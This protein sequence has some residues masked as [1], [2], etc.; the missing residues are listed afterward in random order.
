[1]S[2]EPTA[3]EVVGLDDS[4]PGRIFI[5]YRRQETAWPARQLHDVLVEYFPAE[6]VFKDVDSIEP[7]DDFVE[8]ITA[9]VGSCDVLLALIGPQWV[10][11]ID[12][13]G[14]R[15][16]DDPGDYVRVEIETALKRKIRVIPIL[17]DDAR[18]PRVNEL[19][20][21]LAPLV[22]RNAV[23]INPATFDTK[24]LITA[25]QKTL[26]EEQAQQHAEE[27]VRREV[28]EQARRRT[29]RRPSVLVWSWL[30]VIGFVAAAV[31]GYVLWVSAEEVPNPVVTGMLLAAIVVVPP[32]VVWGWR[33]RHRAA[34]TSTRGQ[35]DAAA[36]RLA[37]QTLE[38]WS[39]QVVERGIQS[40]A[41][42]RVRW[43]WAAT[44]VALPRQELTAAPSLPTDPGPLP[45]SA[46]DPP[47]A[48][49]VLNSGL[50][51]RLHDEVYARL[52]HGRL[53]LI[54]GPGAGKTGA[55]ILLLL[56]ALRYRARIPETARIDVPVPVWLTLGS[57]DPSV[58]GLRDW[59]VAT[60]S[61]DHPYLRATDF[62]PDAMA[63]LFDTGRIALFLDGLDEMPDMQ[64]SKAVERLS[65]E[66]AGR[67]MVITSRPEE[68]RETIDLGRRQLPYTAAIELRQVGP[69]AAAGYLLEGQIGAARQAWQPVANHLLAHPDSVLAKT[70]NT[71]LTLSL[72]RAAYTSD[73][74]RAL[75]TRTP[76]DEHE[77]RVHLLDQILIA[78]Y[79]DPGERGHATHWLGWLAHKMGNQPNGPIRELRW[80]QIPTWIP[81]WQVGLAGALLGGLS[82]GVAVYLAWLSITAAWLIL[83]LLVSEPR[84]FWVLLGGLGF[85]LFGALM[86]GLVSVLGVK[87]I[88]P[89]SMA[90]RWPKLRDIGSVAAMVLRTVPVSVLGF[91]LLSGFGVGLD[92]GLANGL[93]AGVG[94][95]LTFGLIF[96]VVLGVLL[97][98]VD[99]W[100]APLAAMLAVTPRVAYRRDMR[101]HRVSGLMI[102]LTG[103][104]VGGIGGWLAGPWQSTE[105]LEPGWYE[106]LTL[107]LAFGLTLGLLSG[108]VSGFRAG[109]AP[110]LLFTEIALWPRRRRVRFMPLLET[111][112]DRQVLRQAGAVYQFRHADLQD[113]LAARYESGLVRRPTA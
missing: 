27:Q 9:A 90:V 43:R 68:F 32:V 22:R 46:D 78:A 80:W 36:N 102:G 111:A 45:S 28:E 48:G 23:E 66:A 53:V 100:R 60:L 7:G 104:I 42:V 96:G 63:Q 92:E 17:V 11:I 77:L 38:T 64:R 30:L 50:V 62:G 81:R 74:P 56:E 25:V 89:R 91:G 57:W 95:G 26:A 101:S 103:G 112:M 24:R 108:L 21:T 13:N 6:Q 52:H 93:I 40:P 35:V 12:E 105:S 65:A 113:R 51:T 47:G 18:M 97:G 8:R 44:D 76:A 31:I 59:V 107:G 88:A 69:R 98:L 3:W 49:H 1:L 55:M 19:P 10:T 41:P 29:G 71:P 99:V 85:G 61:R 83:D 72:A 58:Q 86:V 75:L 109:A 110:S 4:L 34:G 15:R 20:A 54:G 70:L 16:L 2:V 73:D 67:R 87:A 37:E 106:G 39:R 94:G 82:V 14:R 79:P 84:F 33:R 5:C